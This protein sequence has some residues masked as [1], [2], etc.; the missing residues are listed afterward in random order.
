VS[1]LLEYSEQSH[2]RSKGNLR[3]R[4]DQDGAMYAQ[5][6]DEDLIDH[7]GWASDYPAAPQGRLDDPEA[8]LATIL[9]QHG[10]FEMAASYASGQRRD[11]SLQV[12]A[13]HGPRAHTVRVDRDKVPA[14]EQLVGHLIRE[15]GI[16]ALLQGPSG[17]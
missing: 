6:N 10:F 4:V 12:L 15:L 17:T 16:A 8:S 7:H 11:G 14:F 13:W 5:R 1:L 9:D 3:F 2:R